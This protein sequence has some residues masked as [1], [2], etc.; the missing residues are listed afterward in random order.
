M[1]TF[2]DEAESSL[3]KSKQNDNATGSAATTSGASRSGGNLNND[4]N[5]PENHNSGSSN[6]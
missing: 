4:V 2:P 3:G 1:M 6:S 5:N